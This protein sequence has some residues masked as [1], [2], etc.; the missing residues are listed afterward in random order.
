MERLNDFPSQLISGRTRAGTQVFG[1]PTQCFCGAPAISR[2]LKEKG[3][4]KLKRLGIIII[5]SFIYVPFLNAVL[6]R[7]ILAMFLCQFS[8]S[9]TIS[10][11]MVFWRIC[12]LPKYTEVVEYQE[13]VSLT[14]M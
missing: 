6:G 2:Y 4:N 9:F 3:L 1:F 13:L 5:Q 8:Y 11:Y 7:K 12:L 10:K 14:C